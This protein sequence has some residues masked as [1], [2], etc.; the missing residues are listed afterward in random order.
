ME[1]EMYTPRFFI[2]DV[3]IDS[4]N[5]KKIFSYKPIKNK[6]WEEREK[7]TWENVP[8]IYDDDCQPFL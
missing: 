1:E 7:G 3:N 4:E 2:R 6:Y 8:R 5:G